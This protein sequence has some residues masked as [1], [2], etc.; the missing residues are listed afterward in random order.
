[1]LEFL[2][3]TVCGRMLLKILTAPGLSKF[4]GKILD[5]RWSTC[6]IP[7]FIKKNQIDLSEYEQE[8]YGSFNAFF[9]RHIRKE[10][11]PIDGRQDVMIAP[12]DGLLTVY[13]IE[14]GTVVP[15]KQS[16]YRVRDLLR[17][18]TLAEQFDGGLCLV[19]RL[20][21]NHYHRYGYVETG[22][23][24]EN[25]H[26]DGILHTVRPIALRNVPVF[27]ENAREYTVIETEQMGKLVQMEVGAMLVGRIDNL[28]GARDVQR[29]EEKGRFLYGGSTIIVLVQKDRI[30][31][32]PE[33]REATAMGQEFPVKMGQPIATKI[34]SWKEK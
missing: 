6:L 31:V 30:Q 25:I 26:L 16:R 28:H 8:D 4:C 12:C 1:M 24:S 10:V 21:V 34:E 20:C 18:E 32:L 17:D 14:A 22:R 5:S 7:G 2:Y 23:K 9:C 15:V 11:R 13:P 19:Y 29:G 33:I 27:T 3:Q